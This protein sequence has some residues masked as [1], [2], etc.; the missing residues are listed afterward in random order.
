[1]HICTH[2]RP[3]FGAPWASKVEN[4]GTTSR[5]THWLD[6]NLQATP[7]KLRPDQGRNVTASASISTR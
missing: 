4:K 7:K 6:Q 5:P 2:Q 3:C 1:M